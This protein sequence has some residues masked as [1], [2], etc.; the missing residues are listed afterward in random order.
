MKRKGDTM[1]PFHV[2]ESQKLSTLKKIRKLESELRDHIE[3]DPATDPNLIG[4]R[5]VIKRIIEVQRKELIRLNFELER[6][7]QNQ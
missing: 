5:M 3:K 2:L 6:V 1:I 4:N 7:R